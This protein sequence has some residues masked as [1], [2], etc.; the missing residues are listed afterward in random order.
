MMTDTDLLTR[1]LQ[2]LEWWRPQAAALDAYAE[3]R[4]PLARLAPEARDALGGRM[5]KLAVNLPRLTVSAVAERLSVTG[6]RVDG[7]DS[8]PDPKVWQFGRVLGQYAFIRL[9]CCHKQGL[10]PAEKIRSCR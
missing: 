6:F 10:K 3:G 4:Q 9:L 1:L 2:S 7:P 8:Q 5:P